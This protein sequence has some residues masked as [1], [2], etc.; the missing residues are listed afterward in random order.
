[1]SIGDRIREFRREF[2]LSQKLFAQEVGISQ[3]SLS[4]IEKNKTTPSYQTI[5]NIINRYTDISAKWLITGKGYRFD[6]DPDS[7]VNMKNVDNSDFRPTLEMLGL[8]T[9]AKTN[10]DRMREAIEEDEHPPSSKPKLDNNVDRMQQLIEQGKKKAEAEKVEVYVDD[11]GS[12]MVV[13]LPIDGEIAAGSPVKVGQYDGLGEIL[14]SAQVVSD[15]NNFHCFRVNG[16]SMQPEIQ[17][18]DIVIINKIYDWEELDDKI[19]AVRVDDGITLKV[20]KLDHDNE[21][22]W[23]V[24][25]NTGYKPIL[26]NGYS[27][28]QL[29]GVMEFLI[30]SYK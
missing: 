9:P 23:L 12:P 30:R 2:K 28:I 8:D 27:N 17:N 1:M 22:S 6:V 15:I 16:C 18:G 25:I 7:P 14:V 26:L 13:S 29:L 19:V 3:G 5:E 20:L 21:C 10:F 4:D 24:P 11:I